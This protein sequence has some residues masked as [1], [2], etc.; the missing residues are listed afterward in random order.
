MKM[1]GRILFLLFSLLL[2][3]AGLLSAAE[4]AGTV[5]QTA[6]PYLLLQTVTGQRVVRTDSWTVYGNLVGIGELKAGGETVRVKYDQETAGVPAVTV[7][8]R[9]TEYAVNPDLMVSADGVLAGLKSGATLL[10]DSRSQREWD[11]AH[12]PG[13]V[14]GQASMESKQLQAKEREII[15]YGSSASDLRPFQSARLLA[16]NGYAKIRVYAGGVKEWRRQGRALYTTPAHLA[17]LLESGKA[18]RVIDMRQPSAANTLLM[19]G[20]EALPV[21]SWR[22]SAIFLPDRAYQLPLFLYGEERDLQAAAG[23]LAQ[24][25]Y[26]HDGDFALLDPSWKEWL[27]KYSVAKYEPGE[28]PL[29]EISLQEFRALW[30]GDETRS[31]VFLNVK[32]KRDREIPGEI[33]IPLEELP[34]RLGELPRDREIIIYCSLGL[35]SAVAQR[36]LQMNGFSSRFVNRILRFDEDKKPEI[37]LK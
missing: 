13:A 14:I 17:A 7:V 25:G 9:E 16:A 34:E 15:I 10:F 8:A 37:D 29:E 23:M 30:S 4:I 2:T 24:W 1:S 36:I 20:T 21:A 18:F 27:G 33:H 22:R 28:L 12:L 6:G 11:E 5:L 35:R 32:A 31:A 26:H 19:S 3:P